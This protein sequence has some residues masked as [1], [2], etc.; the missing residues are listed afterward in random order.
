LEK[1]KR[2]KA[3]KK[4][5]EA[6]AEIMAKGGSIPSGDWTFGSGRHISSRPIP[7]GFQKIEASEVSRLKGFARKSAEKLL[8]SRPRARLLIVPLYT[9]FVLKTWRKLGENSKGNLQK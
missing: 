2:M 5:K 6:I 9:R 7:V 8:K 3:T 4:Q 1:I